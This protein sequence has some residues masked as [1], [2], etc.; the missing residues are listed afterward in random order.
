MSGPG[1]AAERPLDEILRGVAAL[2]KLIGAATA[3]AVPLLLP[4]RL[5]PD[6]LE[7]TRAA[8]SLIAALGFLLAW[9]WQDRLAAR[10]RAVVVAACAAA[11]LAIA[12]NQA[13]VVTITIGDPAQDVHVL[14]GFAYT[15]EGE[16]MLRGVGEW[17]A[18]RARQLAALGAAQARTLWGWSLAAVAVPYTA[19]LWLLLLAGTAALVVAG[20][21]IPGGEEPARGETAA[22]MATAEKVRA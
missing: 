12:L 2:V 8:G 19:A 14:T 3:G 20:G 22:P 1:T 16:A 5:V 9:A 6:Q 13:F 21:G 11:F 15:A 18:P 7:A 17:D 10:R 4:D